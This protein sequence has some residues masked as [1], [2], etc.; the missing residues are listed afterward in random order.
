MKSARIAVCWGDLS[1]H[2]YNSEV[3][4]ELLV[5][6]GGRASN[7]LWGREQAASVL[8]SSNGFD[9]TI[10]NAFTIIKKYFFPYKEA[11]FLIKSIKFMLESFKLS[12]LF[13]MKSNNIEPS[14][15]AKRNFKL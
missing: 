10:D 14:K 2:S 8:K 1:T 6:E 5:A 13:K 15:P 11:N 9:I 3:M 4:D 12:S 7:L